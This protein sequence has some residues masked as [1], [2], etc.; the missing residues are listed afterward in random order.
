MPNDLHFKS[1]IRFLSL[2]SLVQLFFSVALAASPARHDLCMGLILRYTDLLLSAM[3]SNTSLEL[4]HSRMCLASLSKCSWFA[5]WAALTLGIM[6][7]LM[8]L[9]IFLTDLPKPEPPS[10]A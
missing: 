9:A 1:L 2:M 7:F 3:S 8:S 10:S 6:V 5:T 4:P